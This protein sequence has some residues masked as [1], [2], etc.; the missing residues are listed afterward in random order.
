MLKK[1]MAALLATVAFMPA[2]QAQDDQGENNRPGNMSRRGEIRQMLQ[3]NDVERAEAPRRFEQAEQRRESAQ[4]SERQP[5]QPRPQP[6]ARNDGY[7]GGEGRGNMVAERTQRQQAEAQ[8]QVQAQPP[9]Q[10]EGDAGRGNQRNDGQ[11]GDW[12][13]NDGQRGDAGRG[14]PAVVDQ[15]RADDSRRFDDRRRADDP[16]RADDARRADSGRRNDGNSFGSQRWDTNRGGNDNNRNWGNDRR[17]SNN[18]SNGNWSNNSWNGRNDWSRQWRN[19]NRYDWGRYRQQNRNLFRLPRYYAPYDWN[20]GYRRFSIGVTLSS[21]LWE[22]DYWIDDPAYYRLP[23]AYGP[24]RWV[25]YY[26]D[27][28]LVDIRSGYVV[29]T[30]YDIFW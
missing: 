13:R 12:Q 2:A 15:R 4:R 9:R 3:R 20:Y 7:R 30:V 10:R 17:S 11:R 14:A 18:W 28:L 27:A 23:P 21:L 26:N 19:D 16:R 24:Y 1:V 5:D 8:A 22:Q 29:D 6:D 25:R